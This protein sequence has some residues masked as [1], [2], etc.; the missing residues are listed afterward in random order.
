MSGF[1]GEHYPGIGNRKIICDLC[2]KQ[3]RVKQTVQINDRYNLLNKMIVCLPCNEQTNPQ[4]YP[5][6]PKETLL[7]NREYVRPP[8]PLSYVVQTNNSLLPSAPQNLSATYNSFSGGI[9]LTWGGPLNLGSGMLLGFSI[10]IEDPA[11]AYPFPLVTNTNS[12][13]GYYLDT[14]NNP[15][16]NYG[17]S[18]ACITTAGMGTYCDPYYYPI[19]PNV[20]PLNYLVVSQTN[21][22][23]TTSQGSYIVIQGV[24]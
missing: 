5:V 14:A 21:Y 12:V 11:G 2:G 4:V 18:V 3:F 1:T 17:Y 22:L 16:G 19:Q 6:F 24:A 8:Q 23:L 15:Q 7:T 10:T 9:Q 20:D 13:A